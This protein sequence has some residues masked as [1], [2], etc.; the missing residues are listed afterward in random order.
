MPTA[1][2]RRTA[3][4]ASDRVAITSDSVAVVL[5]PQFGL[6]TLSASLEPFRIAKQQQGLLFD[7][8]L[9]TCDGQPV[10]SNNGIQIRADGGFDD[11]LK[12]SII[13][14]ISS[15]DQ[16][17]FYDPRLVNWLRAQARK[18]A[19]LAPLGSATVLAAKAG[20]LDGY[21]C[22]THWTLHDDFRGR[23]PRVNLVRDLYCIDRD[24]MTCAGGTS[25]FD[26]SLAI[27]EART[28]RVDPM[29][30]EVALH[31]TFRPPGT[32]QR[33][34]VEWRYGLHDRAV[35]QAIGVME[36]HIEWPLR[37][38]ALADGIGISVR[39]LERRFARAVDKAPGRFYL[40]LRLNHA[41]GLLLGS[42]D[43]VQIVAL[44]CGFTDASHLTRCYREF[45]AETPA[46]TRRDRP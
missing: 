15:L 6:L 17:E 2:H 19:I 7:C 43:S 39:Q 34:S 16:V 32:S 12:P 20:L 4:E 37:L 42:T 11:A 25:G 13:F 27:V 9:L 1:S 35:A 21:R 44:R 8:R 38:S 22:A 23:F 26:L 3:P 33:P 41:R 29:V 31:S 30:A 40:E 36:A 14:I 18:G 46:A 5:I 45:F 28:K 10:T 24:R